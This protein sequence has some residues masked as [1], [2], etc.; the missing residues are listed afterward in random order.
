M[1]A[2]ENYKPVMLNG[3]LDISKMHRLMLPVSEAWLNRGGFL[4]K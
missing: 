4:L 3:Q 1:F 2:E